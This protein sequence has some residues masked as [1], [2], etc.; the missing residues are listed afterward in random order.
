MSK[1]LMSGIEVEDIS[2]GTGREALKGATVTVHLIG[3]L[4]KGDVFLDTRQYGMPSVFVVGGHKGIAGLTK[5]VVGMCVG[6]RRKIRI[7]PHLG[8]GVKGVPGV[9]GFHLLP[10]PPNAVVIFDVE[11]LDVRDTLSP[12]TKPK[13]GDTVVLTRLPA[14]FLN[15][16]PLKDQKAISDAVGTRMRLNDYDEDGRAGL[17]FRDIDGDVHFIYVNPRFIKVAKGG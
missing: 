11:L 4:N 8:Y 13:P 10:V 16:L 17:E 5:G 12:Q 1:T 9:G 15:D 2:V 6:G 3:T 14:K 7:S